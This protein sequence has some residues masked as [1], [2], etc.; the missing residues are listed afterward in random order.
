LLAGRTPREKSE[1]L[2]VRDLCNRFLIAKR[3][4]LDSGELTPSNFADYYATC[5][6]I[7]EACR[8]ADPLR[9]RVQ[10]AFQE[11]AAAGQ[12]CQGTAIG[13]PGKDGRIK[14][15]SDDPVCKE[16][17][18]LLVRLKLKRP[19]L[20]FYALRQGFETISGGS[21]DQVAVDAIMGH[22]RND[23][24]SIYREEIDDDRLK[25]VTDHVRQ[26]LFGVDSASDGA[27]QGGRVAGV[28]FSPDGKKI[29]LG[30]CSPLPSSDFFC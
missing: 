26:W 23:M 22:S 28:R 21:R 18:K 20:S 3:H 27:E 7:V 9:Q 6:R 10:E 16:F 30:K 13:E 15:N 2:T 24:A 8:Y 14:V 19:G 25:A 17:N 5:A 1:G 4:K 12:T 29:L 11:G